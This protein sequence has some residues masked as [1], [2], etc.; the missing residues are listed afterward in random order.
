MTTPLPADD[1]QLLME[2][3]EALRSAGPITDDDLGRARAAYT[4]RTVDDELA[5]AALVY[6]SS[7]QDRPLVRGEAVPGGRTLIFEGDAV[8]VEVDATPDALLGRVV[9]PGRA[10][11]SLFS[12][13]GTISETTADDMGSFVLTTAPSGPVR[14]LCRTATMRLITDWVRL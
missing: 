14:F 1:N 11:I 8:S 10:D 7:I 9:P 3:G 6:D 12:I 13:D 5:L 4:W 2:L